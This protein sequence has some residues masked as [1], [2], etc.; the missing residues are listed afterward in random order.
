[1]T[2]KQPNIFYI[3]LLVYTHD[4]KARQEGWL[5]WSIKS[6]YKVLASEK[7]RVFENKSKINLENQ[8]KEKG[9]R[10]KKYFKK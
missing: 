2:Y 8:E 7:V 3:D 4:V 9:K 10:N 1:M 5:L 6:P